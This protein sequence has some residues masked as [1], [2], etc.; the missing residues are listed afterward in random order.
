MLTRLTPQRLLSGQQAPGGIHRAS[1]ILKKNAKNPKAELYIPYV[2]NNLISA[3]KAKMTVLQTPDS[4][5]GVTYQ[6]DKPRVLKA[7]RELVDNGVY[8]EA[9]WP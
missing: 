8:P 6:D 2:V 5:F 4:W 1:L 9:L 7:I 3:G